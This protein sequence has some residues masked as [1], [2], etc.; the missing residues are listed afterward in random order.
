M[1]RAQ[2]NLKDGSGEEQPLGGDAVGV[3]LPSVE[4]S[5]LATAIVVSRA[6]RESWKLARRMKSSFE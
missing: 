4:Q 5:S 1:P 3:A 2:S 6:G